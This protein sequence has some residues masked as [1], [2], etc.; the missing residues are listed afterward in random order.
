MKTNDDKTVD[1]KLNTWLAEYCCDRE[2]KTIE[3]RHIANLPWR[4]LRRWK[5]LTCKPMEP[6]TNISKT[7]CKPRETNADYQKSTTLS[8]IHSSTCATYEN[9]QSSNNRRSKS[10][11]LFFIL[12]YLAF[13]LLGRNAKD[14]AKNATTWLAPMRFSERVHQTTPPVLLR[15]E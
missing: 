9:W 3:K 5:T 10:L 1:E 15:T 12:C 6:P 14:T 4:L 8:N 11:F 7:I 13:G 2:E